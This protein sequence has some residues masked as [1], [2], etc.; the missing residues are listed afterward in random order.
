MPSHQD[1]VRRAYHD[2]EIVDYQN[3]KGYEQLITISITRMDIATQ[4]S[5]RDLRYLVL[6]KIDEGIKK[7]Y[8][9]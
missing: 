4:M 9:E 7:G 8:R 5:Q 6:K 3:L 2:I 1:R